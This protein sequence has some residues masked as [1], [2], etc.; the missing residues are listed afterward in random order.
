VRVLIA[1][2]D[3]RVR[4]RLR[5]PLEH[6]GHEILETDSAAGALAACRRES[7]AVAVVQ[8]ALP[9]EDGRTELERLKGDPDAFGVAVVSC[10]RATSRSTPRWPRCAA[11]RRT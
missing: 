3:A 5:E 8:A 2:S 9:A 7:P 4:W 10:S 1:H 11:A 6:A